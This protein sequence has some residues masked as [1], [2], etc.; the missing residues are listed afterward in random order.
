MGHK[1]EK[2]DDGHWYFIPIELSAEF[3]QWLVFI[4]EDDDW[5][6]GTDFEVYRSP[7][8]EAYIILDWSVE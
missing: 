8:P 7:P 3:E 1:F 2:D 5:W 4:D 6:E